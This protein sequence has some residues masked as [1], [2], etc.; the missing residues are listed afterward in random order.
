MKDLIAV[1][2]DGKGRR[3]V[4]ARDLHS[5]LEVGKKFS[6]WIKGRIEKYDFTDGQDYVLTF[7]KTGER[8]NVVMTDYHLTLD[9][10]KE[11]SMVE[12]NEKGK[13]ARQYFIECERIAKQQSIPVI[14]GN[15]M[16]Q[17]GEEMKSKDTQI[18]LLT[19][20]VEQKTKKIEEQKPKVLFADAVATSKTSILVGE[21]AK[22]IKQNGYN[23][24]QNRLFAWL[25]ENGYLIKQR[26]ENYNLPAQRSM[27]MSLFEIKK[28]AIAN[29]DGSI[30]TTTTTKVTGK[31]QQYFVNKFLG[32]LVDNGKRNEVMQ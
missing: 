28:R 27:E 32:C 13:E 14:D 11:L 18:N 23:I 22:L 25:R 9:M 10:A 19:F 3:T 5:F 17:L 30:R 26:G 1:Q 29:A 8:K 31:G 20:D 24:G 21:L 6:D 16:I 2:D 7:P 12:R 15:F 4:N